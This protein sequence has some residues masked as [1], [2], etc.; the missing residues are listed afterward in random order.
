MID[1]AIVGL[2]AV[3]DS[4]NNFDCLVFRLRNVHFDLDWLA[5]LLRP[6]YA[7]AKTGNQ[8]QYVNNFV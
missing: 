2:K 1:V 3:K 5:I 7:R 4:K 6:P 8:F